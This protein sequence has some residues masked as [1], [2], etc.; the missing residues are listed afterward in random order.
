[1]AAALSRAGLMSS[2]SDSKHSGPN[3]MNLMS[4]KEYLI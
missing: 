1:M 2:R 3:Y 4:K